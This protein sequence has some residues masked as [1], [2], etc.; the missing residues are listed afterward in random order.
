MYVRLDDQR[1]YRSTA[2]KKICLEKELAVNWRIIEQNGR[3]KLIA[4]TTNKVGF[5]ME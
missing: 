3:R 4:A 1:K 2:W 5:F